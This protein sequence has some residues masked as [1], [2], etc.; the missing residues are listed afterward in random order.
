MLKND[1]FQL[2]DK[3]TMFSGSYAYLKTYGWN[4]IFKS[5]DE[6]YSE[7]L[8]QL[9]DLSL[10]PYGWSVWLASRYVTSESDYTEFY[11]RQLTFLELSSEQLFYVGNLGKMDTSLDMKFSGDFYPVFLLSSSVKITGGDGTSDNPYELGI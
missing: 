8:K 10:T 4:N 7:D 5:G 11:I 1:K 6:N 2:E 3:A 9:S